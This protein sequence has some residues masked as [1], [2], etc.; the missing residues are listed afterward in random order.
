MP[1][2]VAIV[3]SGPSAFY[4]AEALLKSDATC[5]IDIIE[6]LPAP[7]GLIRYGVAP[8]HQTTKNVSRS[9]DRIAGDEHVR[10]YGNVEVDG[11]ISL[12]ELKA[13]YDAVVLAARQQARHPGRGQARRHRFRRFRRLV[14]RPPRISRPAAEPRHQGRRRDR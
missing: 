9:Y 14:Q 12:D 2:S 6:R 13:M 4:T 5:E 7:H 3:G 10:F 1:L 8:D 11:Q